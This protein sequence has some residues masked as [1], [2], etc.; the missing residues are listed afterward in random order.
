MDDFNILILRVKP[1]N[2]NYIPRAEQCLD[3]FS[4]LRDE[5]NMA[6]QTFESF[7]CGTKIRKKEDQSSELPE[8]IDALENEKVEGPVQKTIMI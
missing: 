3:G 5:I 7:G 6:I 2:Q 1:D 8:D 4:Q